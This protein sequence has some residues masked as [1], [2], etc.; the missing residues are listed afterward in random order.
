MRKML[1]V[2]TDNLANAKEFL[3]KNL[4]RFN[5]ELILADSIEKAEKILQQDKN[6]DIKICCLEYFVDH[7]TITKL[8]NIYNFLAGLK[9]KNVT[10]VGVSDFLEQRNQ[11]KKIYCCQFQ[12]GF[13]TILDFAE[14]YK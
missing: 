13:E 6:S 10:I 8:P 3:G 4:I 12:F 14:S 5:F 1:L 9:K 2:G 11:L 7:E